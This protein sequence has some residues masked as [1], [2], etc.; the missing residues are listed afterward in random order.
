RAPPAGTRQAQP[1]RI[2]ALAARA[3]EGAKRT[4]TLDCQRRTVRGTGAAARRVGHG[5]CPIT[6]HLRF[7]LL[8]SDPSHRQEAPIPG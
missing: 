1:R 7:S 4:R 8:R 2:Q 3:Q 6:R 5:I